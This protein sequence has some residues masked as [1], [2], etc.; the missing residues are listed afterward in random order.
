[1][2]ER[3]LSQAVES[4]AQ[5]TQ[6]ASLADL[7]RPWA[8]GVYDE[9]GVRFAFFRTYEELRELA[10]RIVADRT[11]H[12]LPVTQAQRILTYYHVAQRE[13]QALIIGLADEALQRAPAVGEWSVRQ[14]IAHVTQAAVG[15]YVGVRHGLNV[16]HAGAVL[17]DRIPDE[18]WDNLIGLDETAFKAVMQGP[19][20]GLQRYHA[21]FHQRILNEFCILGDADLELPSLYWE[22][23]PMPIRFRLHRFDSHARQHMVQIEKT[24][25]AIG[26]APS[27]AKILLRQIFAALGEIEGMCLGAPEAGEKLVNQAAQVIS[28]RADDVARVLAG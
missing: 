26:Q 27:E 13:L 17:P 12:G 10:V 1:M 22:P 9:E 23:T 4:F 24:L 15:F 21:E 8:W 25:P 14:T 6:A 5:V 28:A 16:A 20:D 18:A 3:S 2:S 11:A 7:D 19:F